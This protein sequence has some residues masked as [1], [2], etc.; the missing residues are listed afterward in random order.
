MVLEEYRKKRRFDVTSEPPGK[1]VK[2]KRAPRAKKLVF[3]I[4]G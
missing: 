2:Q 3:V 1:P 4:R